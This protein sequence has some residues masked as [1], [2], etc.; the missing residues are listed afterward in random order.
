MIKI[1][2]NHLS[3]QSQLMVSDVIDVNTYQTKSRK[4]EVR[5]EFEK[6][7]DFVKDITLEEFI[8]KLK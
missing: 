4:I 1:E 5:E 6:V 7:N 2:Q 8:N 3:I